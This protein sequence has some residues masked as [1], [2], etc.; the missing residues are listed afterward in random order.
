[1]LRIGLAIPLRGPAGMYGPSSE[2]V[3]AL[4]VDRVNAAGGILGHEVTIDVLDAGGTPEEVCDITLAA[5]NEG[6]LDAVVG[7]HI[8]SIREHLAPVLTARRIPYVYT[9]LHEGG[10]TTGVLSPGETPSLQ[11]L[12]GL[13]WLRR[14]FGLQRWAIVGSDYI[15]PQGT[16][17]M[18]R[19]AASS[20][21]IGIVLEATVP[22]GCR[23]FR[24]V[25]HSIEHSS[26]QAVLMLLVG[27]DAVMFN[28]QFAA[29]DLPARVARF[30]PLMEESMLLAS[31]ADAT[32][33]LYVAASYF[34]A[35]ATPSALDLHGAYSSR[36][37]A[38]AP[39]LNNAAESCF[40]GILA[41][42]AAAHAAGSLDAREILAAAEYGI[43]YEGP[44]GPV[45]LLGGTSEQPV[46]LARAVGYQFDV[47]GSLD[48]VR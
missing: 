34:S 5:V 33:N 42:A 10:S 23:S 9:A 12:P 37:G 11:V 19:A 14:S 18:V 13:R 4:A 48:P 21:D 17:T 32:A 7:W 39:S 26:A 40:E 31:G 8:S 29:A 24:G 35:L 1:M 15:W 22:Y 43:V 38:D 27:R 3:G 30:S 16:A 20:V 6:R 36:F 41:L 28:R 46:H 47:L 45:H 44:R 25:M 2:A